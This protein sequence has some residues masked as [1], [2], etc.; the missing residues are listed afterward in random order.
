MS[1][2]PC[3]LALTSPYEFSEPC[4]ERHSKGC[5]VCSLV[6]VQCRPSSGPKTHTRTPH[7]LPR[8]PSRAGY[9]SAEP[10]SLHRSVAM[11]PPNSTLF[12]DRSCPPSFITY[13]QSRVSAQQNTHLFKMNPDSSLDQTARQRVPTACEACRASKLRCRPS[14]RPGICQK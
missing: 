8:H 10:G 13:L 4:R 14:E 2:G 5:F 12:A 11:D 6:H 1:T 3:I 7:F 9:S